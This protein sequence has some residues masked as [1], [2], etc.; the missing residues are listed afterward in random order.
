MATLGLNNRFISQENKLVSEIDYLDVLV[1]ELSSLSSSFSVFF[2]FF[3][4]PRVPDL[5]H[6]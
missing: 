2:Q 6:K 5:L 3:G 4:F 1:M